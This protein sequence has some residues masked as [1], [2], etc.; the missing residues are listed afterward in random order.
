MYFCVSI[1]KIQYSFISNSPFISSVLEAICVRTM[2]PAAKWQVCFSGGGG[3]KR[4]SARKQCWRFSLAA[5][6]RI[7][8]WGPKSSIVSRITYRCSAYHLL[9]KHASGWVSDCRLQSGGSLTLISTPSLRMSFIDSPGSTT[10]LQLVII[11]V[12][13]DVWGH[14]RLRSS[15]SRSIINLPASNFHE[16]RLHNFHPSEQQLTAAR[17]KLFYCLCCVSRNLASTWDVE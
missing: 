3:A 14:T 1:L 11:V 6:R 2:T 10:H 8:L 13:R 9:D 12:E 17:R 7:Y 15:A 5:S 16:P 4:E